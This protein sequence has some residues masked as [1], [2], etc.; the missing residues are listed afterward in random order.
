MNKKFD[1]I[2]KI[3][4]IAA[5]IMTFVIAT[6]CFFNITNEQPTYAN[7]GFSSSHSS[8]GSHSSSHSSSSHSSSSSSSHRSSSSSSKSSKSSGSS[9][10]GRKLEP[11]EWAIVLGLT[12]AVILFPFLPGIIGGIILRIINNIKKKAKMKNSKQAEELI[13]KYIPDFNKDKFL[14]EQ[15]DNYCKIQVAWMNFKLEDVKELLTDEIYTMWCSQLD[16]LELKGEQNIMDSFKYVSSCL[17]G[18]S[19]ENGNLTAVTEYIIKNRDY[20]V[21]KG[22]NKV[23][24]GNK[25]SMEMHYVTKFR[26]SVDHMNQIDKCPSCGNVITNNTSNVCPFCRSKLFVEHKKWVLTE[27]TVISQK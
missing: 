27:Q 9:G 6:F 4:R 8:G 15:Y 11:H 18:A 20:I 17:T 26:I 3:F 21:K 13:K 1:K 10:T 25:R 12:F 23:I 16:T 24:R 22:T 2:I 19:V 14:K 7:A 5:V